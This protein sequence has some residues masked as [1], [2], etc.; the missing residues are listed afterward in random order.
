MKLKPKSENRIYFI[1]ELRGFAVLCMIF[2]HAF[3]LFGAFFD[4]Q[5]ANELFYFFTPVQPIFAGVFIFICGLSC[6]L[7]KSNLKR[8]LILLG[9][10]LGFTVVTTLIMPALGFVECEVYF[11]ILHFLAVSVLLYVLISKG[12]GRIPPFAGILACTVLYAFT[13]GI[14][15]GVLSFGELISFTLSDSLYE[16]NA[17]MILGIHSPD[18][19]AA[20]YFPLF[21]QIFIFFAGVFTGIQLSTRGYPGWCKERRT[22]F[23]AFLGRNTLLIYVVH[24]PVIY[25]LGYVIYMIVNQ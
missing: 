19:Y 14:D 2:Y 7:S 6:T 15:S 21:P 10:A 25:A 17:L 23:F 24:M 5:W 4:W 16:S 3:Y 22:A 11:G 20:D 18:F 8:G 12:V 1:D 9:V 13:S